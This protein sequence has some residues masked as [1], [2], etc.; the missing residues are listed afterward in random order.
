[1]RI[2]VVSNLY[3]PSVLGGYELS[4]SQAADALVRLCHEV[5]VL[6][7][8]PGFAPPSE[9][10]PA[11]AGVERALALAPVFDPE[12]VQS[13][14]L[15]ML[16]A[17]E[18]RSQWVDGHNTGVLI[19]AIERFQPDVVYLWNLVGI[20]GLGLLM[21]LRVMDVP[22]VWHLCD[23][24]PFQLCSERG[25]VVP[26]LADA[27]GYLVDGRWITLSDQ[28]RAE[29]GALGVPLTG[30]ITKLPM[31]VDTEGVPVRLP[32][33]ERSSLR[34]AFAGQVAVHKGADLAVEAVIE[35]RRR[36][37]DVTLDLWGEVL[38]L[39][40]PGRA[41]AA[42]LS[43]RVVF[44]GATIH[45]DVLEGIAACDLLLFPTWPREP[46]G[47][48]PAEAAAV[49]T[50]AI[51]SESG[52]AEWLVDGVHAIHA[53][54]SVEGM[55]EAVLRVRSGEI[56]LMELA[57]SGAAR[58]RSDLLLESIIPTIERELQDA[59]RP[60]MPSSSRARRAYG[61]AT[62]ADRLISDIVERRWP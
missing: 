35:L 9:P 46:F 13:H 54:R 22:W 16:Q 1:M 55:V 12:Q 41:A 51:L 62:I 2:L 48:V 4:C 11:G 42:G 6:T 25:L 47:I 44:H 38:D 32:R 60:Y 57:R 53:P 10:P 29:I 34:L 59:A 8:Q 26:P 45:A 43:D 40:L 56:D 31:W 14:P 17:L 15:V 5:L 23:R 61:L 33:P 20:G 36:G 49:G 3:P 27:F 37:V 39:G 58:V 50:P 19:N 28:L 21:A 30:R 7:T 52:V 24:V 18:A